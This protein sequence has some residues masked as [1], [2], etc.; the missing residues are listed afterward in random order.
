MAVVLLVASVA[1]LGRGIVSPIDWL[2]R[3]LLGAIAAWLLLR[4]GLLAAAAALTTF[5]AVNN[6]P[7]TLA[8]SQWYA[9]TGYFVAAMLCAALAA[10]W[11]LSRPPG[12][13]NEV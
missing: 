3:I 13:Y 7:L 8:W 5:Y 11:R 10:S 2:A 4:H 6:T 1:I 9:G 12:D